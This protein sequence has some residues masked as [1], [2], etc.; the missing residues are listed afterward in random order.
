MRGYYGQ[1][2]PCLRDGQLD[3]GD[4]GAWTEAGLQLTGRADH[5]LKL[6]NGE[7]VSAADLEAALHGHPAIQH[8]VVAV[9]GALLAVIEAR[10]GVPARMVLQA[11]REVNQK[12]SA[13][14]QRL[15]EVYLLHEPM[16]IDNGLLTASMKVSRG[17]VLAL[18]RAWRSEGGAQLERLALPR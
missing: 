12:Q 13:A 9:D 3:T 15:T 8:A 7:K 17:R 1:E 6:A 16:Q 10:A 5:Q 11:V 14:W 4:L 2:T 18:L